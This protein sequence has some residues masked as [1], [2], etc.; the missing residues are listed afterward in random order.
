MKTWCR[1]LQTGLLELK[2]FMILETEKEDLEGD[3]EDLAAGIKDLEAI[4][5]L[6]VIDYLEAGIE[7]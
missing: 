1:R 2:N 3:I 4:E 5:G 7:D 6:E